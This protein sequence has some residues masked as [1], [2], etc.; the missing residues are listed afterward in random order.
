[1]KLLKPIHIPNIVQGSPE[2]LAWR[3]KGLGSSDASVIS[4]ALPEA[5]NGFYSLKQQL[6]GKTKK[7]F[8]PEKEIVIKRGQDLEEEARQA[9]CKLTK[10]KMTPACFIHPSRDW[11]RSSLDGIDKDWTTIL[12]IKCSGEKVYNKAALDLEIPNYYIPQMMH[13]LIAV[14]SATRAHFW[15]YDPER[16]GVLF[17]LLPDP[18]FM[19]ELIR[20]EQWF[21][22]AIHEDR[23]IY[24]GMLGTPIK[25]D[26]SI[27]RILHN[28]HQN[29]KYNK[30]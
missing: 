15:M 25:V 19:K 27:Y 20:R 3:N 5:W 16:G 12:E 24:S 11:W 4:G 23:R 28:P 26:K 1:M 30:D 29:L 2:W 9:Y 14:P 22:N 7:A 6:L 21:W 17:E 13:Q 18:A 8:S 10:T